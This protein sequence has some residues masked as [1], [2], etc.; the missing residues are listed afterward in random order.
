MTDQGKGY[1]GVVGV[2]LTG[3]IGFPLSK[4][5]A[6]FSTGELNMSRGLM[7]L[8]IP[9]AFMGRSVWRPSRSTVTAAVLVATCAQL[10][11]MAFKTWQVNLSMVV[12]TSG[13]LFSVAIARIRGRVL[14]QELYIACAGV[15]FGIVLALAPWKT[16]S[17]SLVGCTYATL[18]ALAG[19]LFLEVLPMSDDNASVKCFWIGA[20]MFV[21]GAAAD[22][23]KF[24]KLMGNPPLFVGLLAFGFFLGWLNLFSGTTANE[25]LGAETTSILFRGETIGA[26]VTSSFL[27]P[28]EG[29]DLLQWFGAAVFLMFSIKLSLWL[30]KTN[31][32]PHQ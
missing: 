5:F 10:M 29:M 30:T 8:M 7:T 31:S 25:K 2:W 26:L 3:G 32:V 17:F 18:G 24:V 15:I 14:H 19:S 12:Y 13:V 6:V 20:M 28:E 9:L 4:Y 27:F 22:G 23:G 1:L 11:F 16:A 21:V